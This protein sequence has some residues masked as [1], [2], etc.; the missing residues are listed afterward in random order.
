MYFSI[1]IYSN[2]M[3]AFLYYEHLKIFCK[4]TKYKKN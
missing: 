3:M 1:G 4:E 2:Y